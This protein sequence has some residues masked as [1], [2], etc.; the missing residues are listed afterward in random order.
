MGLVAVC[1]FTLQL[2]SVEKSSDFLQPAVQVHKRR[3]VIRQL[4]TSVN[5]LVH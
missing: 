4:V 2:I 3:V 1:I 5:L